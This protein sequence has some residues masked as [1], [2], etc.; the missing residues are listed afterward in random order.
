MCVLYVSLVRTSMNRENNILLY[1]DGNEAMKNMS[2]NNIRSLRHE[3][4]IHAARRLQYSCLPENE[5]NSMR[6]WKEI[7][8]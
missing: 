3:E 4:E 6:G 7:S 2:T 8:V 1:D 5:I